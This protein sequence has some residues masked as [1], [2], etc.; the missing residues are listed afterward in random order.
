MFIFPSRADVTAQ[1]CTC[2]CGTVADVPG[3][4][5]CK[6]SVEEPAAS[7]ADDMATG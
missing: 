2:C 4:N 6:G 3:C 7:L 5:A 1:G